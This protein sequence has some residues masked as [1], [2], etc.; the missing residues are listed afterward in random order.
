MARLKEFLVEDSNQYGPGTDLMVSLMALFL[1]ITFANGFLYRQANEAARKAGEEA[2]K[3]NEAARK[4]TAE[5]G[6]D[7]F[8]LANHSFDAGDFKP[9]PFRE[10][11][12]EE[13]AMQRINAIAREYE[14]LK[15]QYPYIFVIGH[16]SELDVPNPADP[17]PP[18]RWERN[19]NFAG[20]RAAMISRF[21]QLQ[22]NPGD[23]DKLVVVST[24]E[25]DQRDPAPLSQT[26]AWV[27]VV[28]GSEWKPRF[29]ASGRH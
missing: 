28:F 18:A 10:F 6:R 20:E 29:D 9:M 1:V 15:V 24:G 5:A 16:A 12:D 8:K 11:V 13:A 17:S 7:H 19:W 26:N 3:A 25:F 14:S 22:L 21:L 2:R 23:R 4:A 27:Q